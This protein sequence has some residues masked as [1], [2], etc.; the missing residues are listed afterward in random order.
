MTPAEALAALQ[1]AHADGAAYPVPT[2][3]GWARLAGVNATVRVDLTTGDATVV[4][5]GRRNGATEVEAN[6]ML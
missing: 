6:G 3:R 1:A 4:E 5:I 2:L